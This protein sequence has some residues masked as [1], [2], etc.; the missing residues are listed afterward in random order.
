MSV[1]DFWL[2]YF[3]SESI[4]E[5]LQETN[6]RLKSR[7]KRI[8][9][10][11]L[12]KAIGLLYAVTPDVHRQRRDYWP[13]RALM[14][15]FQHQHS[16]FIS[17]WVELALSKYWQ[18]FLLVQLMMAQTRGLQ[19]LQGH[20]STYMYIC[21]KPA[22]WS[23]VVCILFEQLYLYPNFYRF[24]LPRAKMSCQTSKTVPILSMSM[25]WV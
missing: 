6:A 12:Y 19:Q 23:A 24:L 20:S 14:T 11:E 13:L 5:I 10:G 17:E 9:M 3:P 1:L 15:Y 4:G 2:L 18:L 25:I 21:L 22:I 7:Q 8:T 16:V